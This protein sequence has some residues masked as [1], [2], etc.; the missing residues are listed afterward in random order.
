ML[1]G[2]SRRAGHAFPLWD[3]AERDTLRS[4]PSE[5]EVA[6]WRRPDAALSEAG[7]LGWAAPSNQE[8]PWL[9]HSSG[10][11]SWPAIWQRCS[12][13]S[14]RLHLLRKPAKRHR[15][16]NWI[17]VTSAIGAGAVVLVVARP[18][19]EAATTTPQ[20]ST[21]TSC[22][23]ARRPKRPPDFDLGEGSPPVSAS[24]GSA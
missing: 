11:S 20:L 24:M 9:S 6:A 19:A 3:E 21:K 18:A 17:L 23:R 8:V 15:L 13:R 22:S 7:S 1:A 5:D 4:S 16:R 10:S 14:E 2:T 12:R